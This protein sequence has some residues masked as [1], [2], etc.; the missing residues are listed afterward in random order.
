M[1]KLDTCEMQVLNHTLEKQI[2]HVKSLLLDIKNDRI[3]LAYVQ[4]LIDMNKKEILEIHKQK[5]KF[6]H[7]KNGNWNTYLP[8]ENIEPPYGRLVSKVDEDRL[9]KTIIDYYIKEDKT[10]IVPVFKQVYEMWREV[11]NLELSDNSILR[12]DSDYVRFFEGSNF[13]MLPMSE[14]TENTIK[15]FMLEN[16]TNLKLCRGACKKLLGYI[17]NTVRYARI[18]KI[19]TDNPVEFLELKQFNRHCT[20]KEKPIEE[21]FFVD[22]ELLKIQKGLNELYDDKPLYIPRYGVELAILTGM[23]VGEI[24]SLKWTDINADCIRIH[25]SVKH[26]R[27]KNECYIDTTKTKRGREFPMCDEIVSLLKRIKS[28]Q[29][30]HGCLCD[31]IFTNCEGGYISGQLISDCMKRLTKHLGIHG[32]GITA[33][34]KTINSNLRHNGV[35]VT[36]VASMLGHSPEVNE[37]Y[38]TYDTSSLTEKQKIIKDRNAKV[39]SLVS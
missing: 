29:E 30:E 19:I 25:T 26:N 39:T 1:K 10:D 32:G 17:R 20:E 33:L 35:P 8:K 14:I 7:G 36:I 15:K 24:A 16:I 12:Y 22:N 37:K 9:N 23:R 34:R 21:H 38:Y 6:W 27:L 31:F 18:K 13:E 5:F 4:K 28:I 2:K 3:D 11:K